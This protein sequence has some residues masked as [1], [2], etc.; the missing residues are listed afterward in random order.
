MERM[1]VL[2]GHT[3]YGET[4]VPA[5]NIT[6]AWLADRERDLFCVHYFE[7]GSEAGMMFCK[8]NDLAKFLEL[9]EWY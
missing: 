1:S 5:K 7:G 4:F 2:Q 9:E 3:E 6:K 8:R